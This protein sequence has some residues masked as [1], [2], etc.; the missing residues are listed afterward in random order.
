[1]F[2]TLIP[3]R[4]L[5]FRHFSRKGW[6]L[7]RCLH[8]EVRIG[9]LTA[10]TLLT[11][12]PCL[13]ARFDLPADTI[14]CSQDS[15][16]AA[17]LLS[18]VDVTASRVP[19]SVEAAARQV[20][21]ITRD[22]LEAAGVTSINDA[23]K[24]F[25]GI[26][27]RQRG[28]FG[29]QTDISINGGSY[30]GI[31][32]LVN[33]TPI[34]NPQTGH[35]TA[36]FPVNLSDILRIEVLEGAASRVTGCRAFNGAINIITRR[37]A[38]SVPLE[39][40]L[41]GGLYGTIGGE[42]RSAGGFKNGR[43]AT[44]SGSY[45]RSDGATPNSDFEGGKAFV[46][47][48]R[49]GERF[50]LHLQA[51][52]TCSAYGANTF[53]SAAFPDQWEAGRRFLI[54]A[55]AKTKGRVQFSGSVS[56]LRNVDHFQLVR[57]TPRGENF[58]RSDVFTASLNSSTD[59]WA[60][61]T[62]VGAE[63]SEEIIYSTNLGRPL[64][65][66]DYLRVI[67]RNDVRYTRR[68]GRTNISYFLEHH[69]L[70]RSLTVSSG[71][72]IE[73]NN[74]IDSRFRF[75]PGIDL[76][77]RPG[78]NWKLFASYNRA[79]RL[80]SFTDLWYKSETQEGNTGL[81]PEETDAVRLGADYLSS[82]FTGR[83]NAHYAVGRN[84]IDWI[85]RTPEDIY[86]ASSFSFDAFGIGASAT[87]KLKHVGH[88]RHPF[89]QLILNYAWLSQHRRE[90]EPYY[91]SN[92]AM[93]YLRHQFIA[94]L[95]HGFI[96]EANENDSRRRRLASALEAEWSLRVQQREGAYIRYVNLQPATLVPYGTYALLSLRL[97]WKLPGYTLYADLSN[98]TNKSYYDLSNV[99]QPGFT[100]LFGVKVNFSLL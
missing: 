93:E 53:Y 61:R 31:T 39:A 79:L 28:A 19:L 96:A 87:V 80:P 63:I 36:D 52:V 54:S 78:R 99:C 90:G 14:G 51:G 89:R 75:Y 33:D 32:I 29:I 18:E 38:K 58:H 46:S 22:D 8:E 100:A 10:A 76:S 13:S 44:V 64:K 98:L 73:R 27:V 5:T 81:L 94:R 55:D 74:A 62:S 26:D 71:V 92:Y 6:S 15:L 34:N 95:S 97:R 23:F 91:K 42:I 21:V 66:K 70:L 48:G 40:E 85:M 49:Q 43:Y 17:R 69:M 9:V 50:D 24:L 45:R 77:Y 57:D 7:F 37:D 83:M 1:M 60:G 2:Q 35:L 88:G 67:G 30:D 12:S 16:E 41:S 47:A 59:W 84:M 11:A 65:E 72:L 86:H 68:D 3:K 82:I 25:A 20:V 4:V 56:W